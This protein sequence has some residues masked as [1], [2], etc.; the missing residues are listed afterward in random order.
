MEHPTPI[1][2]EPDLFERLVTLVDSAVAARGW[3]GPH[4]L[5]K[6]V[7]GDEPDAFDLGLKD[8]PDGCHPVDELWGFVAPPGWIAMGVVTMGWA[9]PLSDVRPSLHPDRTRVRATILVT[10]DGRQVTTA[11]FENGTAIDEPGEGL[12][13]DVLRRCLGVPTA[14]P[15]PLE[16]MAVRMWLKLVVEE[17][18]HRRVTWPTVESLYHPPTGRASTWAQVREIAARTGRW[19]GAVDW[20]DDGFFARHLLSTMAGIDE[21][22]EIVD[23]RLPRATARKVRAMVDALLI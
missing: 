21:L 19:P 10:R 2:P 14:P 22:L 6:V 8:L 11:S 4:V 20:M 3:Y 12:I 18:E 23:D 9:S 15:P 1:L 5:I 13:E 16:E 17:A 7:E